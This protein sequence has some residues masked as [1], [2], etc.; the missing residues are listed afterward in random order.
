MRLRWPRL[1]T[2]WNDLRLRTALPATP[3]AAARMPFGESAATDAA[4]VPEPPPGR[5]ADASPCQ[6]RVAHPAT[7]GGHR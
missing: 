6:F 4:S 2:G 5:A 1:H 7:A 3:F